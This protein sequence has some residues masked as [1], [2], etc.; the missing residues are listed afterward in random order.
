MQG[1]STYNFVIDL[2]SINTN[3]VSFNL[4]FSNILCLKLSQV[5]SNANIRKV[6]FLHMIVVMDVLIKL[7]T[8][9]FFLLL[10]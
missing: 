8:L 7:C 4:A 6:Y 1:F 3:D 9:N 5:D 2:V 10:A